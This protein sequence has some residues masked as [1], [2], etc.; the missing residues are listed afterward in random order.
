MYF[1]QEIMTTF[2]DNPHLLKKV[3]TDAESWVSGYDIEILAQ[4]F[5]WKRP[6]KPRPKK[7]VKFGQMSR[8]CSLF[9]SSISRVKVVLYHE[10]SI[11]NTT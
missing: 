4:S 5:P 8:F 6:E 3:I 2:N 9:F 1:A 11:R 10:L 7:H